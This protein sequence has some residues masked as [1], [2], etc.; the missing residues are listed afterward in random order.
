MAGLV[1]DRVGRGRCCRLGAGVAAV[2]DE[3]WFHG[4]IPGFKAGD[5]L[6]AVPYRNRRAS[7]GWCSAHA[8]VLLSTGEAPGYGADE[9][10]AHALYVTSSRLYAKARAAMWGYGDVYRVEPVGDLVQKT[11][12]DLCLEWDVPAARV[13]AVYDRVV[14]LSRSEVNRLRRLRPGCG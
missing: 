3:T 4:G 2:S 12:P 14:R 10:C 6:D 5:V 13:L 1:V 8:N 11:D 9:V 7:C